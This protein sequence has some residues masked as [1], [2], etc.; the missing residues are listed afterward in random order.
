LCTPKQEQQLLHVER[1]GLKEEKNM[2]SLARP[3]TK[4][5]K[6][7]Q[8]TK[9]QNNKHTRNVSKTQTRT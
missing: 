2:S 4:K 3:K 6:Q 8:K 1:E 5:T 7:K 9:K